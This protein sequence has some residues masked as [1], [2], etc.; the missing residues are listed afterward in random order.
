MKP[1]P[2]A[3]AL[4]VAVLA[5]LPPTSLRGQAPALPSEADALVDLR[6]FRS[7]PASWRIVGGVV[8]DRSREGAISA[9]PGTGVLLDDPSSGKAGDLFTDWQH[10]DIDLELDFMMPRGSNSGIYLQG[11]YEV[12]LLD[13]WGVARPGIHD[14]GAIYERW[15]ES[16]PEGR[17][18]YQGVPPRQNASRAPGL[19]QHLRI[20]FRAPRFDA[21]GR[22]VENARFV[23]VEQNGV[24]LH[25]NVEVTGPTRGSA[26][27]EEAPQG[28]LRIQGDHGPVAFR[29]LRYRRYGLEPARLT[30]LHYR[31][32]EG[33]FHQLEGATAGTPARE[34]A[35]ATLSSEVAGVD[36]RFALAYEGTLELPRSGR[37]LFDLRLDWIGNDPGLATAAIGAARLTIDGRPVVVHEGHGNAAVGQ[38]ELGEGKHSLRLELYKNLSWIPRTD[39]ELYV[40]GPGLARQPLHDVS[41]PPP[42]PPDPIRVQPGGGAVALRSFVRYGDERRTHA[43]SVGDPAGVHYSYDLDSGALLQAW[44]GPFVDATEMWN[45]RGNDQVA[46]PLGSV[47]L[48]SGAPSVAALRDPRAPWPDSLTDASGYRLVGYSVDDAGRPTFEY[49]LGEAEIADRLTPATGGPYLHRELRVKAP[50]GAAPLYVRAASGSE[51]RPLPDG[52]YAVDDFRYYVR[53]ADGASPLVRPDAGGQELLLPVP[54]GSGEATIAYDIIW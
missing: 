33:D 1:S 41:A 10:G 28:P 31:V 51:I 3:L 8:A 16:R 27:A 52:S 34:G 49:R 53:P 30:D 29:N 14:A 4:G 9:T 37:Y 17:K 11:R 32:Y 38:A 2:A 36:D 54:A 25:E 46:T 47:L 35:S 45:E 23:R 19:W 18:G 44:R 22:K 5:S 7:P 42:P 21:R 24:V 6:G 43:V 13:S 48:L 15:D 12:Q 39:V 50:A 26:F 40:E 20:V